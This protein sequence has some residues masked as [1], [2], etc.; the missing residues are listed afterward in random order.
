M[1]LAEVLVDLLAGRGFDD[2]EPL[3]GV[4]ASASGSHFSGC[5]IPSRSRR[6]MRSLVFGQAHQAEEHRRREQLGELLG[7]VALAAVDELVDE[8]VDPPGD[9]L[10]L[11]VHALGREQ[12]VEQLAVL[13]VLR[14]IDVQRDERPDVAQVHLDPGREQLVVAQHE[15]GVAPQRS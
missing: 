15:L 4:D 10:F 7:E 8:P 12:R 2:R 13:R 9:V 14:R 5:R 6:N 1:R 3:V 11:L